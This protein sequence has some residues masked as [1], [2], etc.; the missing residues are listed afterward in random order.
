MYKNNFYT[1]GPETRIENFL[2]LQ[3]RQTEFCSIVNHCFI[4][5][6]TKI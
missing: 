4:L 5:L 6:Q 2:K 1:L 3:F